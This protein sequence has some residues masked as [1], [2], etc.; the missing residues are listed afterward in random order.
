MAPSLPAGLSVH[1]SEA[2]TRLERALSYADGFA[3][4]YLVCPSDDLRRGLTADLRRSLAERGVAL[5]DVEL[6]L[7]CKDPLDGIAACASEGAGALSVVGLA[8]CGDDFGQTA[9]RM[10]LQ[11]ERWAEVLHVPVLLWMDREALETLN[12]KAPDFTA[13]TRGVEEFRRPQ[14]SGY[15]TGLQE[16]LADL[17]AARPTPQTTQSLFDIA[18]RVHGLL[19]EAGRD[20]DAAELAEETNERCRTLGREW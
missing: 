5:A 3:L 7:D 8:R 2:L 6:S 9:A 18:R 15:L 1:N 20:G 11:R 4:Y 19:V 17:R 14:Q 16:L 13:W 10:N 12:E